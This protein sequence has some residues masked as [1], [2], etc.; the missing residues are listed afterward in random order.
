MIRAL[1]HSIELATVF[2]SA[3]TLAIALISFVA[4]KLRRIRSSATALRIR[5]EASTSLAGD[6]RLA[7]GAGHR[8]C[9]AVSRHSAILLLLNGLIGTVSGGCAS[10]NTCPL[11]ASDS[12]KECYFKSINQ[13]WT[14]NTAE[15]VHMPGEGLYSFA[16]VSKDESN[17]CYDLN[18]QAYMCEAQRR[19]GDKVRFVALV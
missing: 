17:C 6:R 16:K 19:N 10:S 4:L 11:H 2:I 15:P 7:G 12:L 8:V 13:M 5:A 3:A 1:C 14:P 9:T 18:V